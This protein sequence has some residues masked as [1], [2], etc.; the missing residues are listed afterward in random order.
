[1]I[2]RVVDVT[3]DSSVGDGSNRRSRLGR[4]FRRFPFGKVLIVAASLLGCQALAASTQ[5]RAPVLALLTE[6]LLPAHAVFRQGFVLGE[7]EVRKCGSFPAIVEWRTIGR[8]ADPARL[9]GSKRSLMIAP[10]ASD[11]SR[12]SRLANDHNINVLLPYQRSASLSQLVQLDSQGLLHPLIPSQQTEID[13]LA[14]DTLGQG[15]RRI[16]VIANPADRAAGM[17]RAYAEAFE[18]L[19]GT[20]DSYENTLVHHV[21]PDDAS[22]VSQF[23]QDV[24]WKR[25]DAIALVADPSGRLAMQ[26]DQAQENGRLGGVSVKTPARVWLL[27]VARLD[28]IQ[29]Q[30]W[31]QLILD[32]PAHGPGWSSFAESYQQRWAEAPDLLA[33]SGFDVARLLAL[34]SLAP[35]PLSSKGLP[36]PIAWLAPDADVKPLC[37]AIAMRQRGQPVRLAGVASDLVLRRGQAPSGQAT[38][39][40]LDD[41]LRSNHGGSR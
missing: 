11:L 39:R 15:W 35:P 13:Q 24:G 21:N 30:P 5:A 19:G 26:I 34:S 7:E 40:V 4:L 29:K 32:Q 6:G 3:A 23:I 18:S 31:A 12:F 1:M 8:D 9:V 25:P 27:P 14:R 36:A 10:F 22:E 28:P 16:M 17:A 33:A 20:V 38:T 2:D 37:E 41:S